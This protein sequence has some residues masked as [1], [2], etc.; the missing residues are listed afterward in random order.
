VVVPNFK[1]NDIIIVYDD[2]IGLSF[3]SENEAK[4]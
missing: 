1:K 4:E 3:Q 2:E